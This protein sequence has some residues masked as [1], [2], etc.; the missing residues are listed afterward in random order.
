MG[1]KIRDFCGLSKVTGDFGIEVEMEC[2]KP[3]DWELMIEA[4]RH[5]WRAEEDGSLKVNGVEFVMEEPKDYD[6]TA[7]SVMDLKDFLKRNKIRYFSSIRS[8]VHI[9]MNVQELTLRQF[10][11]F[12]SIYYP[13]ET[14]LL[15]SCGPNRENNLFCLRMRDAEGLC[16]FLESAASSSDLY[17]I[18]TDLLRYSALNLQ[19]LFKYGSVE[20][21]ALSTPE[22]LEHILYWVRVLG[23]IKE[24]ALTQHTP[25]ASLLQVSGYGGKEF[26]NKVLGEELASP[27]YYE[28]MEKDIMKD[29][30]LCQMFLYEAERAMK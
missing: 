17:Y 18:R 13:L 1:Q 26:L 21:R 19:S 22:D 29:S 15:K 7:L 8:G 9:H 28:G 5:G 24:Y 27:L 6:A 25:T 4:E 11:M 20:F 3:V 16:G 12:L 10:W 23:A 2:L 30:R 14:V